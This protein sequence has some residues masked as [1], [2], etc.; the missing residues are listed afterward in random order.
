MYLA[1]HFAKSQ[2]NR[3]RAGAQLL[4]LLSAALPEHITEMSMRCAISRSGRCR[5]CSSS[6]S[7]DMGPDLN[8]FL[9]RSSGVRAA[10][11]P[12][13][14]PLTA[15]S[16]LERGS[17]FLQTYGCQM[18]VSDSKVVESVL[19][20]YGLRAAI[21]SVDTDMVLLNTCVIRNGA[22]NRMLD[23]LQKLRSDPET[24]GATVGVLWCTAEHLK[25]YLLDGANL[26]KFVAGMDA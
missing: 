5:L 1:I 24:K 12:L 20:A 17:Y 21:S 7:L 10:L 2:A 26:A 16:S 18:N 4:T 8:H 3:A 14:L 23:R 22:E 25:D 9:L 15:V 13:P 11:S 6:Q 19:Q